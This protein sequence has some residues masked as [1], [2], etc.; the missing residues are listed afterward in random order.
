M[1]VYFS[2]K[3]SAWFVV[4]SYKGRR[5]YCYGPLSSRSSFGSRR[6]ALAYEPVFS[7]SLVG[8]V[9]A[10]A[11]VV[12]SSFDQAFFD[13]LSSRMKPSGVYTRRGLFELYLSP[14]FGPVPVDGVDAPFLE[15]LNSKLNREV[16]HGSLKPV[17]SLC[18][19]YLRFLRRYAKGADD[20]L[21]F[22]FVDPVVRERQYRVWDLPTEIRFLS[23]IS[24]Q[25]ER[26]LFS[27]LVFY[28]LRIGEL[29][30]LKGSDFEG[31]FFTVR[32][33]LCEKS[34]SGKQVFTT[35]KT[36][37][38]VRTLPVVS[39][40]APLLVGVPKS[41]LFPSYFKGVAVMGESKVR[42]LNLY[43][44]DKAG[45][46]HPLKIH[47]FRHSCAS[48]LLKAGISVRIVARWLGDT[49]A[50]VMA[51]YSHLFKD[52]KEVIKDFYDREAS[53]V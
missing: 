7:A 30:A 41:W 9:D 4:V 3:R 40:V 25:R 8:S 42:R 44:C 16:P 10:G 13:V 32:R 53:H 22:A 20:S 11:D 31:G 24:D 33:A 37:R 49:E 23:A 47:E 28:G 17:I 34:F 12:C 14:V 39:A 50:T 52:E 36:K 15:R 29:L 26:L 35:P 5:Y 2:K 21:I 6:E 45:L 38:S 43:Y 19:V 18:R 51:T 1:A 48:N 27:L 46:G